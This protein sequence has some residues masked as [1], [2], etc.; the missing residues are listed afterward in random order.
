MNILDT[1]KQHKIKEVAEKKALI[2]IKFLE[3]S[4]FFDTQGV[5]LKKYLNDPKHVGI[6][7]EFKRKSP[8]KGF[9]NQYADPA[10]ISLG[11]MQAGAT[12]LSVLTDVNF[13]GAKNDDLSTARRFN[14]CPILRKDFIVD[15]Y[16][17][18]EAKSMGADVILLIAAI[19]SPAQIASFTEV[20][21]QLKMEVLLEIHNEK[22]WLEN[23]NTPVDLLGINNRN[24]DTFEVDIENS[25][26]LINLLPKEMT[27][28]AESGINDVETIQRLKKMGFK[29]FLIGEYFMKDA[30]PA[31]KCKEFIQELKKTNQ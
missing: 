17:I 12:A 6:I 22:E 8:S 28:I 13:F 26:H 31:Q 4:I 19:L 27:K 24:L 20:A 1:I 7:A 30:D 5:S 23:K 16:Q 9:I 29:G 18:Y 11:Y 3:K 14:Y 21:H 25:E 15:A 10:K 2:P